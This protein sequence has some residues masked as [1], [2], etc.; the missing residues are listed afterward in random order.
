IKLY[1]NINILFLRG[2][3]T[4]KLQL[5]KFIK[6]VTPITIYT[7]G[8]K[9]YSNINRDKAIQ[10]FYLEGRAIVLINGGA[11]YISK[12]NKMRNK[13]RVAI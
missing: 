9:L 12:F 3:G 4:V 1:S 2:P 5:L 8:T 7:S 13:D 11:V 6:K 10:E